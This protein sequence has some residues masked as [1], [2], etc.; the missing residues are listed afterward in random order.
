M[1]IASA[2]YATRLQIRRRRFLFFTTVFVLTSLCSWYM[3]D[4]LWRNGRTLSGVFLWGV[5]VLL[6]AVVIFG[7]CQAAFGFFLLNRG[8]DRRRI[9]ATLASGEAV[10][11]AST[12]VV[13]PVFN[14][15]VSRVFEGVRTIFRSVEA[16]GQLAH[17]D[18]FICSDSNNPNNWIQEEVAWL[19]LCKQLNAFGKIFYRKRRQP[20]NRKSG[21]VSD[22]LRRWGKR[23]RYM[24]VLD[25]DSIMTG[26]TLTTMVRLMEKNPRVGIIQT[27]PQLVNATSL[28]GRIQQFGSR[29]YGAIFS[30][31]LSYWQMSE[32]NYWGHN[33]IIRTQP[34]IEFCALPALPGKEPLGGHILSHDY[35]EAAL[36]RRAGYHVWLAYDL[37]GSYEE[38]PPTLI[39]AAKRDRRWCQGNLQH[40]WLLQAKGLH[41][42]NRLHLALGIMA[43][44]SS[45]LWLAF[46]GFSTL[47]V[48]QLQNRQWFSYYGKQS[49]LWTPWGVNE[50]VFLFALVLFFLFLPKIMAL[51]WTLGSRE[52]TKSFGGPILMLASAFVEIVVSSL[53]AP[54]QMLFHSK[55]VIF[56]LFGQGVHWVT[57]NRSASDGTDWREAIL[58][59]WPHTLAGV[60]WGALAWYLSPAFFWWMSPVILGLLLAVPLS[61]FLST[62]QNGRIA[63]EWGLF[64]V[65]EETQPPKELASLSKHLEACYRH[66]QP[67]PELARD[68]GLLQAVLDPYVNSVHVSLLRQRRRPVEETREYIQ[69]LREKLLFQGPHVLS[70]RDKH[71]LMLDAESM[72]WLYRNLWATPDEKLPQWWRIAMRQYNT[73]T[74][75]P[76]T[77][78]YR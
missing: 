55:F 63:R 27:C 10:P 40:S 18:F 61:I 13:I 16:E 72:V 33:A 26:S 1:E 56:T 37:P 52:R 71:V 48:F 32:G 2:P 66:L 65:P 7:F 24:V 46:L 25:A 17:F 53:L 3:A 28:Y 9:A 35:V 31:G 44:A 70:M 15:D 50:A 39:D 23:Y 20:L 57:Q 14:E 47:H 21:N 77:A 34:F 42:I 19:E 74:R 76:V 38:G 67:H 59:H 62:E 30:A 58:T 64:L 6:T 12:A 11:L 49:L 43:Y 36:M 41:F 5:F 75:D 78:L 4:I 51:V 8:G 29:L 68:Y 45:P 69:K 73:L 60:L 54:V 22:F